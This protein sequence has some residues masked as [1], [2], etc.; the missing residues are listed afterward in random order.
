MANFREHVLYKQ[1][2]SY[3]SEQLQSFHGRHWIIWSA[4]LLQHV[5]EISAEYYS[6]IYLLCVTSTQM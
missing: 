6:D 2:I 3:P 4:G 1:G 5:N